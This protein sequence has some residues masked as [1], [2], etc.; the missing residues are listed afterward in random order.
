MSSRH[1]NRIERL[2]RKNEG[3]KEYVVI[4]GYEITREALAVLLKSIDGQTS[5]LPTTDL[6]ENEDQHQRP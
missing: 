4:D 2:E 3:H 5:G 1:T 6:R